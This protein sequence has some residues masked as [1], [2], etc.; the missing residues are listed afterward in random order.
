MVLLLEYLLM[1]T[2]VKYLSQKMKTIDF[3]M[4]VTDGFVQKT[5]IVTNAIAVHQR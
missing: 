3:V 5:Y 4:N 2:S 1:L